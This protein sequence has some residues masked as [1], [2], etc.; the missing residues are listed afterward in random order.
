MFLV[1]SPV[2]G[3]SDATNSIAAST[4]P[5]ASPGISSTS[6]NSVKPVST[7]QQ[8]STTLTVSDRPPRMSHGSITFADDVGKSLTET[9]NIRNNIEETST[10][11]VKHSCQKS[12][13]KC[14][15]DKGEI[16]ILTNH[17]SSEAQRACSDVAT[18]PISPH[19]FPGSKFDLESFDTCSCSMPNKHKTSSN[20]HKPRSDGV[21]GKPG[22]QGNG[23]IK[24]V[25]FPQKHPQ[26]YSNH[27]DTKNQFHSG[28]HPN[29]RKVAI[30]SKSNST[31][32]VPVL[33]HN[34]FQN[35]DYQPY[36]KFH[37]SHGKV[38]SHSHAN[39]KERLLDSEVIGTSDF[40]S[41]EGNCEECN[42][43]GHIPTV[44][45]YQ[46]PMKANHNTHGSRDI[47][48][49][50]TNDISVDRGHP[51]VDCYGGGSCSEECYSYSGSASGCSCMGSCDQQ[52]QM[53][54]EDGE[55]IV[56]G[57][58]VGSSLAANNDSLHGFSS[59]IYG[60]NEPNQ[61]C[62]F[63]DLNFHSSAHNLS[64]NAVIR[65]KSASSKLQE[66]SFHQHYH[67]NS[68]DHDMDLSII[69]KPQKGQHHHTLPHQR[70]QHNSSNKAA[71]SMETIPL[72]MCQDIPDVLI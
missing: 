50:C 20:L 51:L 52:S 2:H 71:K 16:E 1:S 23:L 8:S 30:S 13:I 39:E 45:S 4:I 63:T 31:Q 44:P 55:S 41:S 46:H 49:T 61:A 43:N 53:I 26:K 37:E 12:Q 64:T 66:T 19:Y 25:D 42:F 58:T 29:N 65:R 40:D 35:K 18:S 28:S 10:S 57:A 22:D 69:L 60:G 67:D 11:E 21:H 17:N 68:L 72:E 62:N 6:N 5:M 34:D 70:P 56:T 36:C 14:K 48:D 47:Q 32:G 9:N 27:A 33:L 59:N 54:T 24:D 15:D 38:P 3:T 7:P